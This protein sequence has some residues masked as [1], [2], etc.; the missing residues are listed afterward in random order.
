M[1]LFTPRA[2]AM[3]LQRSESLQDSLHLL[4]KALHE[5][6]QEARVDAE[7]AEGELAEQQEAAREKV[8]VAQQVGPGRLGG[9]GLQSPGNMIR[10]SLLFLYYGSVLRYCF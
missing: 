3:R 7:D 8:E 6:A 2:G 4:V 1:A 5:E 10:I 9:G